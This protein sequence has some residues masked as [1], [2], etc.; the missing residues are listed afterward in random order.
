MKKIRKIAWFI[1]KSLLIFVALYIATTTIVQN[2]IKIVKVENFKAKAIYNSE[3]STKNEKFYVVKSEE[4]IPAFEMN[5]TLVYPG[6]TA[7]IVTSINASVL[8]PITS[9]TVSFFVGG[10]AAICHVKNS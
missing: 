7:D 1:V 3:L 2:V 6:Y 10:H 9:N 8:G 5:G 4:E